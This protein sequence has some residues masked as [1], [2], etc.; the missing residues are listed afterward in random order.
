MAVQ[1]EAVNPWRIAA[2]WEFERKRCI[3]KLRWRN[4]S[5]G[6]REFTLAGALALPLVIFSEEG[7]VFLYLGFQLC[8]GHFATGAFI[9]ACAGGVN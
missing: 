1:W 3:A 9:F 5:L 8:E 4:E 2:C 7:L 6:D